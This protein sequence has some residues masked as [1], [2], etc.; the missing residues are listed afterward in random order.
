MSTMAVRLNPGNLQSSDA[1]VAWTDRKV[2]AAL[3]RFAP[4]ITRVE[5]HVADLNGPK[6]GKSDLRC[7]MEVR[8]NGRKPLVVEHRAAD[9]YAAIDGAARKLRTAAGRAVDRVRERANHRS[10][11]A[12]L[13]LAPTR[14]TA[15]GVLAG[16]P[17]P[18]G[19]V[20][21]HVAGAAEAPGR[22]R[23]S[24]SA[25]GGG[26]RVII[27]GFGPVGRRLA[28]VLGEAGIPVTI[29]DANV[30]TVATQEARGRRIVHGDVTD[31]GVLAAAGIRD[32]AAIAITIPNGAAAGRASEVAR[33]LSPSVFIAARARHLSEAIQAKQKGADAVTVEE[34]ITAQAM[35]ASVANAVV[36]PATGGSEGAD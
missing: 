16:G 18:L 9:L 10:R 23:S 22:R 15:V 35:A 27:A 25:G 14:E 12:A 34:L 20:R 24:G 33:S 17:L 4:R 36:Y 21:G 11:R 3:R 7:A 32:A 13:P 19:T 31:A 28:D 8:I 1:L 26:Q 29:I 2:R 30:R 5:V 6:E